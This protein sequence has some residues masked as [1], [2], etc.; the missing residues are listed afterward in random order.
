[1]RVPSAPV[2][3]FDLEAFRQDV[4]AF[5]QRQCISLVELGAKAGLPHTTVWRLSA[6]RTTTSLPVAAALASVCD[7]SLDQYVKE[8]Q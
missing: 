8:A 1:M 2:A 5:A 6:C 3:T 4:R 7:L